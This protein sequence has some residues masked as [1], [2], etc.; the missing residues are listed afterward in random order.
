MEGD[1]KFNFLESNEP[2]YELKFISQ[3]L[4]YNIVLQWIRNNKYGFYHFWNFALV[5]E[6]DA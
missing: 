4:N 2:R 5:H 1:T 6:S 3:L